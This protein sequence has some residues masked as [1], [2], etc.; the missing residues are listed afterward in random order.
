MCWFESSRRHRKND[1]IPFRLQTDLVA[2]LVEQYTFNVWVLG[3]SPSQVTDL[4]QSKFFFILIFCDL[5]FKSL[6]TGR[7]LIFISGAVPGLN[8]GAYCQSVLRCLQKRQETPGSSGPYKK[9]PFLS[10]FLHRQSGNI[11]LPFR[12]HFQRFP[13][14]VCL[15]RVL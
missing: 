10:K 8:P 3:S 5:V 2:Q 4:L 7:L 1:G 11:P 6:P 14:H 15:F 13:V 9:S 12:A